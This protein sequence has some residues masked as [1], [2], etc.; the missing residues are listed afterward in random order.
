[1]TSWAAQTSAVIVKLVLR[2]LA[3]PVI[4]RFAAL[5]VGS[6]GPTGPLQ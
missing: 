4:A 2:L 3:S 5:V 6:L 1:V